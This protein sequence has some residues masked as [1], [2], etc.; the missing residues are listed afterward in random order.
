MGGNY[1]KLVYNYPH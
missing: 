1:I